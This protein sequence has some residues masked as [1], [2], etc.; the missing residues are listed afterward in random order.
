MNPLRNKEL[1][2][3]MHISNLPEDILYD[4]F[5]HNILN[6]LC[7]NTYYKKIGEQSEIY[8]K[9]LNKSIDFHGERIK[10][11]KTILN[12]RTHLKSK[13]NDYK[14]RQIYEGYIED[15]IININR[16]THIHLHLKNK[17][18]D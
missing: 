5:K 2:K 1:N 12:I 4:I 14:S 7:L 9:K 11:H 8:N 15:T 6:S 10:Q 13:E 3:Q 16:H 17:T 18:I